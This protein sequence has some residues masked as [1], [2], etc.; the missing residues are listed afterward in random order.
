MTCDECRERLWPADPGVHQ[1]DQR[2]KRWLI[3]LCYG[4]PEFQANYEIPEPV[5]PNY[6]MW[7]RIEYL[8]GGFVNLR[9]KINAV[10]DKKARRSRYA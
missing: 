6:R 3:P 7:K 4:C 10:T 9:N 2:A 8:E 5:I 1:Y